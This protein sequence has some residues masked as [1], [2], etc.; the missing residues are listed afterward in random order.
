MRSIQ[1]ELRREGLRFGEAPRWHGGRLWYSD[2]YR[3]A[4]YSMAA[5]G[6]DERLELSVPGQPSG[7]GWMP[8]GSMLVVSMT[9]HRVLRWSPGSEPSCHAELASLCGFWANDLVVAEDGSAYVGNFGFDLDH[10]LATEGYEGLINPPG[11]PLTNLVAL[12]PAGEVIDVVPEMSFPNGMVISPAGD[13]LVVAETLASRLTAFD[14]A[15]DGKLSRRRS[16]AELPGIAPDGICLDAAG[17]IWVA[18]AIGNQALRVAEGGE[19]TAEIVTSQT[20]FACALGGEDRREIYL[21]TGQSSN[22]ERASRSREGRIE[23]ARVEV[24]GAG[25]P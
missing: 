2:F 20:C 12:G 13:L 6:G 21:M 18:N 5:D 22:A 3:H 14:V 16:F 9:D 4:V 7:L 23:S 24:P 1:A 17:Q 15:P 19:I 11:P 25:R 10:F 8:D